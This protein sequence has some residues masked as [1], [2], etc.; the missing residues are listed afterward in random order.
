MPLSGTLA[1]T[2]A[3]LRLFG[4]SALRWLGKYVT[5]GNWELGLVWS[6]PRIIFVSP[7]K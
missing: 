6:Q 7:I 1:V 3:Y 2:L 4:S 5:L